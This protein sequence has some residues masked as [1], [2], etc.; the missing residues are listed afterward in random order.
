[1]ELDTGATVS[2]MSEQQWRT[3]F[4]ESKPLRQYKGKRLRGY[5]GYEVQVMDKSQ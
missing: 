4:T 2:V 3:L 5:S 1:M